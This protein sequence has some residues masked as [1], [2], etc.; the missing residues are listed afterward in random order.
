[1]YQPAQQQS[2]NEDKRQYVIPPPP[3]PIPL[4]NQQ[5][6]LINI[7]PPPPRTAV[8]S[9]Q[10]SGVLLPPPPGP[11]P[12]VANWQ[13]GNWTRTFDPRNQPPVSQVLLK[14]NQTRAHNLG[15]NYPTP[16]KIPPPHV[17]EQMS[18]TYIPGGDSFG[19]GVG[20]P[21]FNSWTESVDG[22]AASGTTSKK[23]MDMVSLS[24]MDD[25]RNYYQ[26]RDPLLNIPVRYS[27]S[28]PPPDYNSI[29]YSTI[30]TNNFQMYGKGQM[31]PVMSPI[32]AASQWTMD[33]VIAWLAN[34]NFSK[35]WQETFKTLRI[36]G[37]TFLEL[38]TGQ[39]GRGNFGMMHQKV[40]PRLAK[41]CSISGTGW[42][43]AREREEGR[44][45]RSLIKNIVTG[46]SRDLSRALHLRAESA[47]STLQGVITDGKQDSSFKLGR[48]FY[49]STP[50]SANSGYESSEMFGK[51]END[52]IGRQLSGKSMN[53]AKTL[54]K[55]AMDSQT[56]YSS[57]T[58]NNYRNVLQNFDDSNRAHSP[59]SS[60]KGDVSSRSSALRVESTPKSGSPGGYLSAQSNGNLSNSLYNGR[61]EKLA[62]NSTES[63][64]SSAA[65]YGS[66]VPSGATQILQ[67][68]VGNQEDSS[69][70]QNKDDPRQPTDSSRLQIDSEER[71]AD[72]DQKNP[73]RESKGTNRLGKKQLKGGTTHSSEEINFESPTSPKLASKARYPLANSRISNESESSLDRNSPTFSH[74]EIERSVKTMGSRRRRNSYGRTFI[75][76]TLDGWNYRMCEVTNVDSAN[77]FKYILK[78]N[79]CL[80]NSTNI[81]IFRT[82]LGQVDH[83]TELD[84][85]NIFQNKNQRKLQSQKLYIRVDDQ[86]T[87]NPP[88]SYNI[89]NPSET[90]LDEK[91]YAILNGSSQRSNSS[92]PTTG[93]HLKNPTIPA[94]A[95]MSWESS[96]DNI[97]DRLMMIRSSR[98]E[99]GENEL[100]EFERQAFMELAA[101]E[102]KAEIERRQKVYMANK[103]AQ[104]QRK[105]PTSADS[106]LGIVGRNVDFDQPRTSPF[107][108]ERQENLLPQRN[109]P[110]PPAE[111][112]TLTKANLLSKITGRQQSQPR[113]TNASF[114]S[115]KGSAANTAFGSQ[116]G[117][118]GHQSHSRTASSSDNRPYSS[119]LDTIESGR[120]AMSYIDFATSASGRSSPRSGI[121]TPGSTNWAKAHTSYISDDK[122]DT[123]SENDISLPLQ[124][125]V[126]IMEIENE[127]ITKS[128]DLSPSSAYP[129]SATDKPTDRKSYGPNLE[130][131]ESSIY[132][133]NSAPELEFDDSDDDSDDGLFAVPLSYRKDSRK[134]SIRRSKITKTNSFDG[135][136]GIKMEKRPHLKI[137]TRTK[138]GL[139][140]S[141]KSPQPPK[142]A[143]SLT[144]S[145]QTSEYS[146]HNTARADKKMTPSLPIETQEEIDAKLQRRKSFAR[147][148]V[149]ANRPPAES[150]IDHLDAFF[151]NLDLDEPVLEE[152]TGIIDP[153]SS[154]QDYDSFE[155][156]APSQQGT[157]SV[158]SSPL[159]KTQPIDSD[160]PT[161]KALERAKSIQIPS[162]LN[163]LRSVGLGRMK[164]IR[165]VAKGAHE[166]SKR[167]TV[168]APPG[169]AS[170]N[171][172][173]RKSTKMFGANIVQI[174]PERGSMIL[175]K[176]PQDTLPKRQATFRWFKGQLI[177]KGTYGRVYLGMNATT[178]EFLAV[179]QVEIS[180]KA[181]GNDKEKMREMVAALDLEI[182][183]MQHLDHANIV[184]YLGCERKETSISIFLEYI[185]GG[186]V[187]SCLRKHGKFEE[188]VVSSLTRQTLSGLAYLHR[189]G[190]LH[191]DLKADNILLDLD[192]TCKIS[193]FGI[194]KKTDNIYGND[195]SNSMQGSVFWMAPEVV[196]SRGQG[197][198]A[199]VD[200]WSL[201]CVVLEMFAGRRPWSK[202]EIVGAIYK[203]GSLNEAP[204]IPD[205]VSHAISPIAVAFMADCFT[206]SVLLIFTYSV[207]TLLSDPLERPIA[208]TLLS[209]HPFCKLD[210][211]YN[212]F[213]TDLYSKIQGAY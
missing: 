169:E 12:P 94:L 61:R 140:V 167:F 121:G 48:K 144:G 128:E 23:S 178:G 188:M 173:R 160:E 113:G 206:M 72:F 59:I 4:S 14:N 80:P 124:M 88:L 17:S 20:I 166:A 195:A 44:R 105:D 56:T 21:A 151:P 86:N 92:S 165:E 122:D 66:G 81:Q 26:N 141:F 158:E 142:S 34:N 37:T 46:R 116:I 168:P 74:P 102:H 205:D 93:P 181:A 132:F 125:N 150:L 194:S 184:Q 183:T 163:P 50:V 127:V 196:R 115:L 65:L 161:L 71:R 31:T 126:D 19:P 13:L 200:I 208:D 114:E 41:E 111:S 32:D 139:S 43:Q 79:L 172:T 192:G 64:S 207:L 170:S 149:W 35:D 2:S 11:A 203:L 85:H 96:S 55:N 75:L 98:Q 1:M 90:S 138:K 63:L 146:D 176:I 53:D 42:D 100:P 45:M 83:E 57:Q 110:P 171:I 164:S 147:E 104:K 155:H 97:R 204:P 174:K 30:N 16:L 156:P 119:G 213:D 6:T 67:G 179:K 120:S 82:E 91:A 154:A 24:T 101:N 95:K 130:F 199:K 109:P 187:G 106:A 103:K 197:Y 25:Q 58:R 68:L 175:P 131:T 189:E 123:N 107:E 10:Q 202:E 60:E 112:A 33:R 49:D 108:D 210:L 99:V 29:N 133:K 27:N 118:A 153:E 18:A 134:Q 159:Q 129:E 185:S 162:N 9:H 186:S 201:G 89:S 28:Q 51:L 76:V 73:E 137:E 78:E 84:Y 47:T 148:D 15:S 3:P 180:G 38:G 22:S 69:E 209:Q 117:G 8:Q 62:R 143:G 136:E 152:N 36:Y 39:G 198:S 70:F 157:T 40:Y 87:L 191:R 5:N 190:I 177:G 145:T 135:K 212:F 52:Y 182:D 54:K 77:D 211:N 7:P 193:D